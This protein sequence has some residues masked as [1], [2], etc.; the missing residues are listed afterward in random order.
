MS[1]QQNQSET[2]QGR[3]PSQVIQY[4]MARPHMVN[5]PE[6]KRETVTDPLTNILNVR[7]FKRAM[8]RM[9]QYSIRDEK[10]MGHAFL[11]LDHFKI[12]NDVFGHD[13]ADILLREIAERSKHVV[14]QVDVVGRKGGDEFEFGF[15]DVDTLED[16][17]AIRKKIQ[18]SLSPSVVKNVEGETKIDFHPQLSMGIIFGFDGKHDSIDYQTRLSDVLTRLLKAAREKKT[19]EKIRGAISSE[20][21]FNYAIADREGV[22]HASNRT[23]FVNKSIQELV[24]V[25]DIQL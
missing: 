13:T 20:S 6:L 7:G 11:D 10:Q 8:E 25:Y 16:A 12:V 24:K 4:G 15:Y 2:Y 19:D 22:I 18:Q 23:D 1:E 9:Q 17:E 5:V 14:R 3:M 21:A